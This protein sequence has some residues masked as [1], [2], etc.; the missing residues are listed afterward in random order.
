MAALDLLADDA[1]DR[2]REQ[3]PDKSAAAFA[4]Y[5]ELQAQLANEREWFELARAQLE[6]RT[7]SRPV[8]TLV[9]CSRCGDHALAMANRPWPR[10]RAMR[11]TE[12]SERE[13]IA[14]EDLLR[15][16]GCTTSFDALSIEEIRELRALVG[17]DNDEASIRARYQRA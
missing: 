9:V 1:L 12:L 10:D 2:Y 6:L 7:K 16:S 11:R 13:L 17:H 5:E 14:V 4:A 3:H 8:L 15:E